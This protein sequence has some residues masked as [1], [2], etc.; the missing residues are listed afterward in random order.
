VAGRLCVLALSLL[1]FA[2]CHGRD[3][4]LGQ[5]HRLPQPEQIVLPQPSVVQDP[6]D[7]TTETAMEH[8]LFHVDDDVRMDIHRL[9]G[10]TRDVRG[11]H[12]VVLDDKQIVALDIA[13]GEIGLDA[14]SLSLLLNRYVFGFKGSPLKNI[15]VKTEGDHIVQTGVMH[16][17]IDIPF[18]MTAALTVTEQGW[19]RIH[20]TSM[21][22]CGLNG[23][24]LLKAV[25]RSLQDLLDLSGGKGLRV[26]SNDI[27][28]DPLASLPPPRI[29]GRL[30]AVRVDGPE[31]V[32][33]FGSA[34]AP[35]AAPLAPPMPAVNYVYFHG[36]TIRF[37]KLYMVK[38]DLMAIDADASDGFDFYLDYYHT[39]LVNGYH[40]TMPNYGLVAYMPDFDDLG[41]VR[42]KPAPPPVRQ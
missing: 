2:C 11:Q 28:M 33:T 23:Q 1:I 8:V 12:V 20:P 21:K 5:A 17:I 26:E 10:R 15:V 3:L 36:G 35:G 29:T 16:K 25:G 19:I 38:A 27:L 13:Y 31:V 39:Q 42:G 9:R 40:I 30:T 14:R 4:D 34:D 32:Q 18:E 41:T 7:T 24:K 37:G 22:I 6:S